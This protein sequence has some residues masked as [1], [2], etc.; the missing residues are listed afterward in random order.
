M[1]KYVAR[2]A[3]SG[4][5][6]E[7]RAMCRPVHH[8]VE[9]A[10]KPKAIYE[11]Y[12]DSR[13][14]ARITGQPARMSKK[15]GAKFTAGGSYI[16][17]YNLDLRPARR[18]VQAWRASEWPTGAYSILTLELSPKGRGTKLVVDHVGIPESFRDGV[19][20]GWYQYYWEPMQRML[21]GEA[22]K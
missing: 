14:H 21:D 11:A 9:F 1:V 15:V 17:G 18:I 3:N 7:D 22:K 5:T 8:E 10:A 20:K 12:L 4:G 19:D 16:S 6:P 13:R 2:V